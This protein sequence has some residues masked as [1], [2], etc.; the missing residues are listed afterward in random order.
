MGTYKRT[1]AIFLLSLLVSFILSGI[2]DADSE[3]HCLWRVQTQHNTVYL[4][5]SIHM[6][7]DEHY[8]LSPVLEE[9]F[10][11]AE[12]VVFEA[13]LDSV[14]DPKMQSLILQKG[15]Y[16]DGQTLKENLSKET[17]EQLESWMS[18][19]GMPVALFN[20]FRP[21]T[22]AI[23]LIV[24]EA[25]RLGFMPEYGI[26]RY[27]YEKCKE[28]GKEIQALES[29]E[30]QIELLFGLSDSDQELYLQ[31]T[32]LDID[33]LESHVG[34][35]VEAWQ[36]GDIERLVAL[37]TEGM[38]EHPEIYQLHNKLNY[39]RNQTWLPRIEQ[40]LKEDKD[41]L[42]I[43]GAL[44]LAGNKSVVDLLEKKG[45]VLEQL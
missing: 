15:M 23:T 4:L 2:A 7:K 18:V 6:L 9:A 40:I 30:F 31:Q 20:A 12:T 35:M 33:N 28:E 22:I 38:D 13:D 34:D 44:H 24:L 32:L 19:Y 3:K 39:Q 17:Y 10:R 27:F 26:D 8:P 36:S 42:I 16:L 21:S 14:N 29:P 37:S 11:Q 25:Q 1:L 5:G 43:V 45:Y 41:Y